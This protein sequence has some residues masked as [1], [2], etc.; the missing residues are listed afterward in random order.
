MWSVNVAVIIVSR[1]MPYPA[2]TPYRAIQGFAC[3]LCSL[4]LFGFYIFWVLTPLKQMGF[5]DLP[6]KYLALSTSNVLSLLMVMI[7]YVFYPAINLAMTPDVD[8]I[9]TVIDVQLLKRGNEMNDVINWSTIQHLENVQRSLSK[10]IPLKN[11][12][13][14]NCQYCNGVQHEVTAKGTIPTLYHID[15]AEINRLV[16]N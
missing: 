11:E 5:D 7:Y 16:Y 14:E 2:P 13:F 9:A 8:G 4:M 1:I 12:N 3:Y 10:K 6:H 15:L